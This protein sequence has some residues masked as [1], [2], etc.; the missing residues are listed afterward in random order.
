MAL[1]TTT[2]TPV[3]NVFPYSGIPELLQNKSDFARSEILF[4]ILN[5]V[6]PATAAGNNSFVQAACTLP[7]NFAYS[8]SDLFLAVHSEDAGTNNYSPIAVIFASDDGVA[9]TMRSWQIF[10]PNKSEAVGEFSGALQE[11][12]TYCITCMPT[13]V[14]R[15]QEGRQIRLWINLYNSSLEDEA[16]TVNLYARFQQFDINQVHSAQLNTQLPVR[17]R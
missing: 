9:G 16:Y 2:L 8:L 5:G 4:T 17:S 14:M 3:V 6:V 11:T 12:L 7:V 13:M 1:I 10:L 15:A